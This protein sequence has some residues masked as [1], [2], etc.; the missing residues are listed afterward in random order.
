MRG[1]RLQRV[2]AD[3]TVH[4]E[5]QVDTHLVEH[6]R[7]AGPLGTR[8]CPLPGETAVSAGASGQTYDLNSTATCG[9]EPDDAAAADPRPARPA[10]SAAPRVLG[11]DEFALRKG[12]ATGHCWSTSRPAGPSTSWTSGQLRSRMAR[13]QAGSG[14]DLPGSGRGLLRRRHPGRSPLVLMIGAHG[15]L[16]YF[17]CTWRSTQTVDRDIQ[18]AVGAESHS[19]GEVQPAGD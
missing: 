17:A 19:G 15:N 9:G 16:D 13:R 18:V 6:K 7:A 2:P 14:A 12:T 4:A 5:Q 10:V 8:R 11:M 1:H 3:R